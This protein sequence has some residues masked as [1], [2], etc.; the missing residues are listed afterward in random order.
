MENNMQSFS[1]LKIK[2]EFFEL[3]DKLSP[4][5]VF[6]DKDNLEKIKTWLDNNRLKNIEFVEVPNLFNDQIDNKVFIVPIKNNP[7]MLIL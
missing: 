3:I 5:A 4:C 6:S 1:D 2:V 7:T